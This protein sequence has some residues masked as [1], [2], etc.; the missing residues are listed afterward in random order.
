VISRAWA[1]VFAR[2]GWTV[3]LFDAVP[4][5]FAARRQIEQALTEQQAGLA[6]CARIERIA[7][8]GGRCTN[9]AAGAEACRVAIKRT[10]AELDR[11]HRRR[12]SPAAL[13][14]SSRRLADL[15]DAHAAVAHQSI[16]LI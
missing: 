9:N 11:P 1:V 8:S 6:R 15:A 4:R 12:Y 10:I 7:L 16:L 3:R 13:R 14:R 5:G 2:A